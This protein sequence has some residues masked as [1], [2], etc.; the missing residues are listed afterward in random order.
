MNFKFAH[1]ASSLRLLFYIK[2]AISVYV[3][4]KINGKLPSLSNECPQSAI[5]MMLSC[6]INVI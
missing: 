5:Q 4:F 3:I 6:R 1:N 2:A